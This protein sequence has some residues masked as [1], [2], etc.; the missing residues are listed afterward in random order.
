MSPTFIAGL[1]AQRVPFIVAELGSDADQF[2][3]ISTRRRQEKERCVGSAGPFTEAGI[4]HAGW[5]VW[6]DEAPR[7]KGAE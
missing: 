2:M 6:G 5:D 3:S 4:A 1:M 7:L